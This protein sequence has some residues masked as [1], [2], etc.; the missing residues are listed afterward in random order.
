MLIGVF[1]DAHGHVEAFERAQGLLRSHGASELYFLGDA[2]GYITSPAVV[3]RLQAAP[4]ILALL[5]NHESMLLANAT[6]DPKRAAVY[7]LDEVRAQL[8]PNQLAF[9]RTLPPSRRVDFDGLRVLFVH[10]SPSDPTY[11][12]VYPDTDL[13][14][15]A[16]IDADVVFMGHTHYP[17]VRTLFGRLFVNVGSCGLPRDE[18]P[19]GCAVLF[20]TIRCETTILRYSIAASSATLLAGWRVAPSVARHLERYASYQENI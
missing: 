2:V 5:G 17:F 3:E 13:S 10:G 8:E 16:G 9:L 20:D 6:C 11:G 1:S 18:D 15:F 7:R 12:Y 14:P 19:R 4:E